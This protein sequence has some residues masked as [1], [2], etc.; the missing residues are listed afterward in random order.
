MKV[1]LID[2]F[3][4]NYKKL[5]LIGDERSLKARKNIAGSF[6]IKVITVLSTFVTYPLIVNYLNPTRYGIFL[7]V[8]SIINW[9]FLL[10]IGFGSGLKNKL[11]EALAHGKID[12]AR[13]YVSSTYAILSLILFGIVL[14]FFF[15]NPIIPWDKLLN[16]SDGYSKELESLIWIVF[17][18]FCLSFILR[19]ITNVISAYQN[20]ALVSFIDMIAQLLS[21]GCLCIL[22]L[23]TKSSLIHAGVIICFTPVVVYT[24]A[25]IFLFRTKY[26]RVRP[27][28]R[29]V[30]FALTRS[31]IGLG[32]KFFVATISA[33]VLF[34]TTNVFISNLVG[35]E[36]V[37]LFNVAYKL[38]GLGYTVI[39]IIATP[40]WA[41][42]SDA[43][44]KNDY[45]WMKITFDKL[46]NVFY[47]SLL[48]E[49]LLFMSSKWIFHLWMGQTVNIPLSVSLA[50]F[51][52]CNITSWVTIC[53][54]PINGIGK[55]KLQFYSSIIEL[56]VII[57]ITY[58]LGH[59]YGTP[60]I[61]LAPILVSLPRAIWAPI[62]LHKLINGTA[63]GVWAK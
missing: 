31:L 62:Q 30:D 44:A 7:T 25:T 9:M 38:F 39:M 60:G 41:A 21:L 19:L 14:L 6:F 23:T 2:I 63:S 34:Q 53:I 24:I 58:L 43:N 45:V 15:V 11:T 42:F 51:I 29:L 47:V 8:S 10:D 26:K 36:D 28:F 57:P 4:D 17:F 3:S 27:S 54:W 22:I 50:V 1:N 12:L 16:V 20:P 55:V 52:Y 49:V 32:V 33:L 40:Y 61:I 56:I 5:F 13:R 59:F 18:S 37:T 46:K 35:P 48:I